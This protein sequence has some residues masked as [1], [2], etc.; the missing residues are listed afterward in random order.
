MKASILVFVFSIYI[1]LSRAEYKWNPSLNS[2]YKCFL[3]D[4]YQVMEFD[5]KKVILF[6]VYGER[7]SDNNCILSHRIP[8]IK[9]Q[10]II[11]W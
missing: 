9:N 10:L 2:C 4:T 1:S 11:I 7:D 6:D 3:D 5:C 8:W